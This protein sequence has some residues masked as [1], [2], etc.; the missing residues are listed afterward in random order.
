MSEMIFTIDASEA[1][2]FTEKLKSL[3]RSN[4]PI[5]IRQTLNNTAFDVYKNTLPTRFKNEFTIR[6]KSFLKSHSGVEKANGWDVNSMKSKV[7]ITPNGSKA[8]NELTKQEFGGNEIKPFIYV[9]QARVSNSNAKQVRR[10]NYFPNKKIV[11]GSANVQR[12]KKSQFVANAIMALKTGSMILQDT[13]NGKMLMQVDSVSQ[14]VKSRK[15]FIKTRAI[16]SYKSGRNI[17]LN[18]H[19]FLEQS[20]KT[21]YQ[22]Q[23]TFF[24]ENAKKR[25][26]KALQ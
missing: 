23:Q 7:G 10:Q 9:D 17:N 11:H 5:A 25:I 15:M 2:R 4:F 14:S 16:A 13:K 8:A 26:E 3:H 1:K 20:S 18:A 22:K 24:I 12:S 21:S 6:N 19:H